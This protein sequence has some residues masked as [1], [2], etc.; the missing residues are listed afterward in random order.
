[1]QS[2]LTHSISVISTVYTFFKNVS[3]NRTSTRQRYNDTHCLMRHEI[4]YRYHQARK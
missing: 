1:M 3:P 2:P 4:S